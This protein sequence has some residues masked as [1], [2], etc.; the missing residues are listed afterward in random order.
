MSERNILIVDHDHKNLKIL[1][2]H[3]RESKFLV[4]TATSD[5]EA[6]GCI[7]RSS[8]IVVLSEL[9]CPGIDGFHLLKEI[10]RS[11]VR[12]GIMV[13]FLS[14]KSDVWTRVKSLKL[15]AKDF[16]VKPVHVR[17]IV[18]RVKMVVQ[19]SSSERLQR[20]DENHQF[21][22]RLED[23]SV[24]DLIEIFG[25]EKK[26]G[27]LALYNENG[28]NGQIAIN[29]GNVF[30]AMTVS[31]RAE[32]AVY[33]MMNWNRGRFTMFFGDID[34]ED[35]MILSNM[36]ILLQGAKRMDLRNELLKQL[37]SLDAVVITTSNFKKILSQ[38]DMNQE[39]KEFLILFDGERTLGRIIDDCRE[40]EIVALKRI[41]KLYKLGFLHVLRDFTREQSPM[42]FK[43][44]EDS[45]FISENE[46]DEAESFETPEND[47][48]MLPV[49][50]TVGPKNGFKLKTVE[51]T[52]L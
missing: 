7:Y 24:I 17:E 26:T 13:I 10:Q 41:V 38:K 22:G 23:L 14:P 16:I 52:V 2:D 19:R 8:Y 11:S 46:F 50:T 42:E 5:E 34:V 47:I 15:G 9:N 37:P 39:L 25:I 33:K 27:L 49:K 29:H 32:E 3:F 20:R 44:Q 43:L 21:S 12:S 18:S 40:N 28:H 4:D 1:E 6:M 45:E 48:E 36:G 35:E 30:G 31:L 51:E